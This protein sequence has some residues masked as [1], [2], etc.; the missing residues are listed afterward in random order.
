MKKCDVSANLLLIPALKVHV[1]YTDKC[2][3][4]S[5]NPLHL[6]AWAAQQMTSLFMF[7]AFHKLETSAV[8]R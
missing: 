1:T 7:A 5:R 3:A 8:R 6:G 4:V 2:I